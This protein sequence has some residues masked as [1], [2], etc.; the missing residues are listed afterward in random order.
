MYFITYVDRVNISTAAAGFRGDLHL[1]NTDLGLIF[2]A[3]GY[4]YLVCQ[5]LGGWLA[6]RYGPRLTLTVC[7]LIWAVATVLTGFAGGMASLIAA[8]VLLGLGEG[9]TFPTAT[10]AMATWLPGGQSAWAQGIVHAAA[11]LGNAITP[12]LI[13]AIMTA[14]S[15]RA[16]F[17]ITGVVSLVWVV[18][19]WRYFRD[20]PRQHKG[21]SAADA[22]R[23]P[24]PRLA[25][26][27]RRKVPWRDLTRRMAPVIVVYF[28]YSC[29]FWTFLSWVP[30]FLLHAYD[31]DLKKSAVFASMVFVGGVAGDAL[32]RGGER[33]DPSADGQPAGG[34]AEYGDVDDDRGAGVFGADPVHP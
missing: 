14:W 5:I 8:R 12:P 29:T 9:A 23:L 31:L 6:D 33:C 1:S 10:R 7:G 4:P 28:C 20:D 26:G 27:A 34:A 11:R 32:G 2:S 13:V 15:W 19:W 3:F 16:S 22:A 24:P 30:Q 21:V 25:A 17:F 18:T